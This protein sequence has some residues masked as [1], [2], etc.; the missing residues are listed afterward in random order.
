MR[1]LLGMPLTAQQQV[2]VLGRYGFAV[3]ADGDALSVRPPRDRIDVR[4]ACDVAE[5][6]LRGVGIDSLGQ[7]LP[8]PA[9]AVD[10][11]PLYDLRRDA[12]Q[13][14]MALGYRAAVSYSLVDPSLLAM[15]GQPAEVEIANALSVDLGALR[16]TLR[17]GLLQAVARNLA[18]GVGEI[19]LV[20]A[21]RVFHRS[22]TGILEDESLAF[23]LCGD[24]A[25]ISRFPRQPVD[26]FDLKGDLEAGLAALRIS[27]VTFRPGTDTALHPGRQAEV[28][29]DERRL[30]AIGEVHPKIAEQLG[31]EVRTLI[32]EISLGAVLAAHGDLV[33]RPLPRYPALLRDVAVVVDDAVPYTAVRQ[34]VREVL[35][36]LLAADALFDV[37][38]G[39]PVPPGKKSLA[40]RL[41]LQS[42]DRTLT[43]ADAEEAL[44]RLLRRLA[45]RFGA[46]LR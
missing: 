38:A 46:H 45:D 2:A 26:F 3:E 32:G 8:P 44:S 29:A 12:L 22:R 13:V 1:T 16:T 28:W 9:P 35:G 41:T 33:A 21:G 39:T 25:P 11:P 43:E 7:E 14:F 15:L 40:L 37:F 20:E 19:A 31:I 18:R 4:E 27:D 36:G 23:I 34:E 24:R 10:E 17:A 42:P 30:G 6:V 5:E